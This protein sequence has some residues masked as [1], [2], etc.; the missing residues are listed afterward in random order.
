MCPQAGFECSKDYSPIHITRV[1]NC[2]NE[3]TKA[4]INQMNPGYT[5]AELRLPKTQY[6]DFYHIV[7]VIPL[8]VHKSHHKPYS[9][10]K[11]AEKPAASLTCFPSHDNN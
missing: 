7:H 6:A 3:K 1:T 5:A 9:N 2:T 8:L 4:L 11:G 10:N